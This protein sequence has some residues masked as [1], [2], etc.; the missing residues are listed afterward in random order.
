MEYLD[1]GESKLDVMDIRGIWVA[2][3]DSGVVDRIREI[4]PNY[5]PNVDNNAIFWASGGVEG[6]PQVKDIATYVAREV[7][8]GWKGC[9]TVARSKYRLRDFV[10]T[11]NKFSCRLSRSP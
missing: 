9:F 1:S 3:D 8:G 7:R 11:R 5:L 6:G 4:A 2:S 10:V